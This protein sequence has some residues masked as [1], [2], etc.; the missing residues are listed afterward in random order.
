MTKLELRTELEATDRHAHAMAGFLRRMNCWEIF[1]EMME[2]EPDADGARTFVL[3]EVKEAVMSMKCSECGGAECGHSDN[4]YSDET[5]MSAIS[6][7]RHIDLE[8]AYQTYKNDDIFDTPAIIRGIN[9]FV[10]VPII[11][12]P[13]ETHQ[14]S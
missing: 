11:N 9:K 6:F 3:E 2:D 10:G 1:V 13:Q 7:I 5:P 12:Q 8:E 14:E 4:A